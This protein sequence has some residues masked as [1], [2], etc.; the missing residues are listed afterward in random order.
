M[1]KKGED[2]LQRVAVLCVTDAITKTS[3]ALSDYRI[4]S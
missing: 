2:T 3:I 4:A 1:S